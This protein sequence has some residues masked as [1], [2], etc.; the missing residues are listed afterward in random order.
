M[1][2]IPLILCVTGPMAAGKNAV[3]SILEEK[4]F[5]SVDADILTHKAIENITPEILKTFSALAKE[6]N[7]TLTAEDGKINRRALGELIFSSKELI[8]KQEALVYPEV[9]SLL[10]EFIKT[11]KDKNIIL[12]ATLLYK[13]DVIKKV[14]KVLFV[15][16]PVFVRFLR[17]KRRDGLKTI[18]ILRRFKAQKNLFAKYK[19][20]GAD[21]R[22]VWNVGS[23]KSLQK[24]IDIF[25]KLTDRG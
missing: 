14:D 11:N 3:S 4:D 6:K 17:A 19:K 1:G 20:S 8:E 15:D 12:N 22:R 23:R 10:E 21:I 16:S 7:I 25:L 5:I 9:N 24:K 13:I 18:Q 2:A